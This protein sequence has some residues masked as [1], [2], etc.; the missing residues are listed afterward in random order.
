MK[1]C[2][3]VIFKNLEDKISVNLLILNAEISFDV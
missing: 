2:S 1:R 3:I